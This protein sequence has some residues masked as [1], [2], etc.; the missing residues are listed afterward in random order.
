MKDGQALQ[1]CTSHYLGQNF[2]KSFDIKFLG[3]ENKQDFPHQTS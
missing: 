2:S 1:S 3:K